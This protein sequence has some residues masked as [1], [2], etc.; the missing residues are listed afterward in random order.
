MISMGYGN[1][2]KDDFTSQ[3]LVNN[4]QTQTHYSMASRWNTWSAAVW[5]RR[6]CKG[7]QELNK[8]CSPSASSMTDQIH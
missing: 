4:S 5:M 6:P 3:G 1:E 2:E 7:S 8:G